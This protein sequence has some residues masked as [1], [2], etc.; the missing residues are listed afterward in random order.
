MVP[1]THPLANTSQLTLEQ[2]AEYP[3]VTYVFG[4]TGRSKLDE[5]FRLKELE[6]RVVFTATDADV[7]KT[8]VSQDTELVP[9]IV[10]L[11]SLRVTFANAST[12]PF[13]EFVIFPFIV[14]VWQNAICIERK[15]IL[16]IVAVVFMA[17]V[18]N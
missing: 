11:F 12:F 15:M 1:K 7:I 4:F 18:L 14:P 2:V 6:P 8:Y 10:L 9:D 17:L 3:I 13:W 5:A 16:K